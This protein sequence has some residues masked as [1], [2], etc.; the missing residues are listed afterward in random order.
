MF[1]PRTVPEAG[2]NVCG[3]TESCTPSMA[4]TGTDPIEKEAHN[5]GGT[6]PADF[7]KP[8]AHRYIGIGMVVGLAFVVLVLWLTFAPW[9]RRKLW[10]LGWLKR[11][12]ESIEEMRESSPRVVDEIILPKPPEPVTHR[13]RDRKKPRRSSR[14]TLEP[15]EAELEYKVNWEMQQH[16]AFYEPEIT[17]DHRTAYVPSEKRCLPPER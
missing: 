4:I 12:P 11:K 1:L 10:E 14:R 15:W 8:G 9:P 3:P 5:Q 2:D 7:D 13:T 6:G 17:P 16:V